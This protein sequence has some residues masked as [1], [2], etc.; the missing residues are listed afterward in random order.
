MSLLFLVH[1]VY[2]R[3]QKSIGNYYIQ[4]EKKAASV[5]WIFFF[6]PTTLMC[7]SKYH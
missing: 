5:F 2:I 1:V 6:K 7:G 4:P 3:L